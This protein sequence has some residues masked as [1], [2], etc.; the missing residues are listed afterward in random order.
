MTIIPIA[1]AV[2]APISPVAASPT[3]DPVT[4]TAPNATAT[5]ESKPMTLTSPLLQASHI[6]PAGVSFVEEPSGIR[7]Y[8]NN[9]QVRPSLGP[10][11][12]VVFDGV[13]AKVD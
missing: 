6:L 12:S 11:P 3:R 8:V 13:T 7:I 4:T 10:S 5:A 2:A 1:L 9:E